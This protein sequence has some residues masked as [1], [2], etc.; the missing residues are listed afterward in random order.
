M[1]VCVF[2]IL[3][4]VC[5]VVMVCLRSGCFGYLLIVLACLRFLCL[6][7]VFVVVAIYVACCYVG[8][9]GIVF[10]IW[11]G[12]LICMFVVLKWCV[13]FCLFRL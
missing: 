7:V 8:G 9:F 3:L 10:V 4:A 12:G 2:V 1:F 5:W 11:C 13:W 6:F